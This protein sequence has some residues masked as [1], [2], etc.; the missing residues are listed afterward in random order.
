MSSSNLPAFRLSPQQRQLWA[1]HGPDTSVYRAYLELSICGPVDSQLLRNAVRRVVARHEILRTY[2]ELQPAM[3]TPVQVVR[4]QAEFV[5]RENDPESVVEL[6]EQPLCA[7]LTRL[8]P[9]H[10]VLRV[11]L[12]SLCADTSTMRKFAAELGSA[13]SSADHHERPFQYADFSEWQYQLLDARDEDAEAGRRFWSEHAAPAARLTL[14]FES[15][16]SQRDTPPARVSFSLTPELVGAVEQTAER[17][18]VSVADFLL[19]CWEVLLWR[20]ADEAQFSVAAVVDGRKFED[21]QTG[22]GPYSRALPIAFNYREGMSFGDVVTETQQ[23]L[24]E[25]QEWQEYFAPQGT[26]VPV[27]GY[28]FHDGSKVL[29]AGPLEFR[30]SACSVW[31]YPFKLK[32][33]CWRSERELD[34]DVYFAPDC[35]DAKSV[36]RFVANLQTLPSSAATNLDAPL[37]QLSLLSTTERQQLAV[38]ND[39]QT[40]LPRLSVVQR[41]ESQVELTPTQTAVVFKD[42]QLTY[43][44]LNSKANQVAHYLRGLGVGPDVAVGLCVDRSLE[45]LVGMLGILKAGGAYV[46]LNP[47]HPAARL[48]FQ[49]AET[50]AS[51]LLTNLASKPALDNPAL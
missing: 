45:M 46:P 51:V 18:Q 21:L 29:Q 28:E 2:F 40:E 10:H 16:K 22:F 43:E 11:S 44:Q 19:A 23:A 39:T 4:P 38:L 3:K 30:V 24:S 25:A 50:G 7:T 6:Q 15:G 33:D 36:E 47:E 34:C 14:P 12:P 27:V 26:E 1:I 31:S 17:A 37:D 49:I 35:I 13:Y 8:S 9:Q 20:Y 5:W 42:Q 48:S 32:L 41:F